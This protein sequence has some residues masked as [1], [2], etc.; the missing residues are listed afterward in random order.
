MSRGILDLGGKRRALPRNPWEERIADAVECLPFKTVC[1][2]KETPC[3]V[4][5]GKYEGQFMMPHINVL[6][7]RARGKVIRRFA[8]RVALHHR[9]VLGIIDS[10]VTWGATAKGRSSAHLMNRELR[11]YLPDL[12]G[13]DIT[14]GSFWVESV[15]NPGDHPSR[16]RGIPPPARATG[17][18]AAFLRGE[19]PLLKFGEMASWREGRWKP[20]P[21][22]PLRRPV[23][24][25]AG[26]K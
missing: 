20:Q 13:G 12:Y 24:E 16:R 8:R 7:T 3:R 14:L 6:E 2:W 26:V 19:G 9:R 10:R 25:F 17:E 1:S 11:K 23:V 22:P 18:L 21:S 5:S 15:R 4:K